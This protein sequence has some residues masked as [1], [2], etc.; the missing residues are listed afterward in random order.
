MVCG[1]AVQWQLHSVYTLTLSTEGS[2]KREVNVKDKKPKTV[3][4]SIKKPIS[5]F[6]LWDLD[7]NV[8]SLLHWSQLDILKQEEDLIK[9]SVHELI[10][11]IVFCL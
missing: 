4:T 1:S 9:E 8:W 10:V 7:I 3:S 2:C 11:I 5:P 6:L